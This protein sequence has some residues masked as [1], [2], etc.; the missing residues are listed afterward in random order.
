M[1]R[2]H[3]KTIAVLL[4]LAAASTNAFEITSMSN[5]NLEPQVKVK[6]GE[7]I[8][9]WCKS[10]SYW[11]WCDITHVDSGNTCE[12]LWNYD[13]YNVKEGKCDD[14]K[15]RMEYIGD[16]GSAVYK[17]GIRIKNAR[18]EDAGQWKCDI[19][20][21]QDGTNKWKNWKRAR[22]GTTASRMFEVDVSSSYCAI[23]LYRKN[24]G[25]DWEK[26]EGRS[27]EDLKLMKFT[28]MRS[29]RFYQT[30]GPC[31]WEVFKGKRGKYTKTL[32]SSAIKPTKNNHIIKSVMRVECMK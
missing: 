22:S 29:A 9:L 16:K 20:A 4:A 23:K 3:L 10:D 12:H 30:Y 19:T 11:E 2:Q 6:E 18:S 15:D 7:P 14:F 13:L 1:A 31:C 32:V 27:N 25:G 28:K 5:S 8:E 26:L 21:Y 24:Y 17:C